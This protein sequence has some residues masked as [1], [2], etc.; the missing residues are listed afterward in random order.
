[1]RDDVACITM[2]QEGKGNALGT[3]LCRAIIAAISRAEKEAGAIVLTGAGK[4]F[5]SGGDLAEL[6]QWLSWDVS[7]R[8]A[9]LKSGPQ[10][11]SL[12]ITNSKVPVIAAVN[13]A[14]YGAGMDLALACD[15][16][17][18]S[19]S[20]RFC[21]AYIK[22]GLTSGD[23]GAWLLPKHVGL[24]RALDLLLTGRVVTGEE[25]VSMGLVSRQVEDDQLVEAAVTL[26]K[27]LAALP[28]EAFV[29][30]RMIVLESFSEN[31]TDHLDTARAMVARL[32]GT[33]EHRDAVERFGQRTDG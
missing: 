5:S 17:L 4:F 20:A 23:G 3:S 27:K 31:W 24:G 12:S 2:D 32:A 30:M 7:K 26:A 21:E 29:R 19:P 6:Q 9:Y 15:V 13:G 33:A 22:V 1:M 10:A 16:R 8:E 25:S 11:L 28:R 14:A 18:A